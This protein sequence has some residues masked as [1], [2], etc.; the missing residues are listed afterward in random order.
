M[1]AIDKIAADWVVIGENADGTVIVGPPPRKAKKPEETSIEKNEKPCLENNENYCI[2]HFDIGDIFQFMCDLEDDEFAD[3]YIYCNHDWNKILTEYYL[4]KNIKHN[5]EL[6]K[7]IFTLST[8][9]E[10]AS[11]LLL[12]YLDFDELKDTILKIA[13][14]NEQEKIK[15]VYYFIKKN[16][17]NNF[18]KII[19]DE[20]PF[21]FKFPRV[22]ID[23]VIENKQ[24]AML[25]VLCE[26]IN[27]IDTKF[28]AEIL[29]T[30]TNVGDEK[31]K[32]INLYLVRDLSDR[33]KKALYKK[34]KE[35]YEDYE[36]TVMIYGLY[37]Y[38]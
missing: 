2:N 37:N 6:L 8:D 23:W 16:D 14:F 13:K 22:Y 17:Y 24:Y 7:K 11:E 18:R 34:L 15:S 9:Y 38:K 5:I 36:L 27:P 29:D 19:D 21:Y 10:F 4:N 35:T 25:R 12:L 26:S 3:K 31:H 33:S 32:H 1:S 30:F 20:L 28:I